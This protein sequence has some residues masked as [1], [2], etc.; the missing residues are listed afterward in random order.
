MPCSVCK[1]LLNKGLLHMASV[2][3]ERRSLR[4][5]GAAASC[6]LQTDFYIGRRAGKLQLDGIIALTGTVRLAHTALRRQFCCQSNGAIIDGSAVHPCRN[7]AVAAGSDPQYLHLSEDLA[8]GDAPTAVA[9]GTA[10][11]SRFPC[12]R[13]GEV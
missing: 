2:F 10:L 7:G 4:G 3:R 6:P 12:L 8:K 11:G 9:T 13:R 1:P 5:N